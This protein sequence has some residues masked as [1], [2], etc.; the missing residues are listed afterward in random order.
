MDNGGKYANKVGMTHE[1]KDQHIGKA[2]F[3]HLFTLQ[4]AML[5]EFTKFI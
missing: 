4:V 1:S 5:Q 2:P 3:L